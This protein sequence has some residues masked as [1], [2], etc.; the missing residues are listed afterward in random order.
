MGNNTTRDIN[1]ELIKF[2]EGTDDNGF[3]QRLQIYDFTGISGETLFSVFCKY[4]NYQQQK[5]IISVFKDHGMVFVR[6]IW[7]TLEPSINHNILILFWLNNLKIDEDINLPFLNILYSCKTKELQERAF[8][9]V[10]KRPT[11]NNRY[12]LFH[13]ATKYNDREHLLQKCIDN[14]ILQNI[15]PARLSD[16]IPIVAVRYYISVGMIPTHKDFLAFIRSG[17]ADILEY[18]LR[19]FGPIGFIDNNGSKPNGSFNNTNRNTKRICMLFVRYGYWD[20]SMKSNMEDQIKFCADHYTPGLEKI[21][22]ECIYLVIAR[23]KMKDHLR[24]SRM[25]SYVSDL[26]VICV[27]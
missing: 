7:E 8:N 5:S 25:R 15:K 26:E 4:C 3:Q 2:I 10:I 19:V 9:D 18:L 21:C 14:G 6:E 13:V 23:K 11:F 17:R 16:V 22:P 27:V 12:T 1:K 20:I 24:G